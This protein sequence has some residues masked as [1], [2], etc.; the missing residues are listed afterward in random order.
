M[1]AAIFTRAVLAGGLFAG[2]FASAT[3]SA[4]AVQQTSISAEIASDDRERGLSWSDGRPAASLSIGLPVTERLSLDVRAVT[5]RDSRR[6]GGADVALTGA[7]RLALIQSAWNLGVG[8]RGHVF[9]GQSGMSYVELTGDLEHTVGPARFGLEA[10]FAPSQAAVGGTNLYVSARIDSGIPGTP[11]T[12]YGGAGHTS[13]SDRAIRAARL[14]PGGDYFD[15][16]VGL[17]YSRSVLAAGLRYSDTSIGRNEVGLRSP[18]VDRHC[19]AR[20][21]AYLRVEP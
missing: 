6:H 4:Q 8:A 18:Y 13:G 7:A 3:A 1:T 20:L 14:R 12:L 21:V 19:G 5:L 11:L 10:A 9:A 17:E 16:H 2:C 15:Y